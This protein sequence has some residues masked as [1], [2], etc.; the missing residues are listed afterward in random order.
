M[1]F[2]LQVL[3]TYNSTVPSS[4]NQSIIIK[5]KQEEYLKQC[6]TTVSVSNISI[7]VPFEKSLTVTLVT[8]GKKKRQLP[9]ECTNDEKEFK[10]ACS[11]LN[12]LT[13]CNPTLLDNFLS[14]FIKK[15]VVS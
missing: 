13:Q 15:S 2:T 11:A 1:Y 7:F 10:Q 8:V 14:N 4:Q 6:D 5:Q 12:D 3:L 9:S